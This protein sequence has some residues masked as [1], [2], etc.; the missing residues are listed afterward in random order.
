MLILLI[1]CTTPQPVQTPPEPV[2][3][4]VPKTVTIAVPAKCPRLIVDIQP[5]DPHAT[6]PAGSDITIACFGDAL[7]RPSM[8]RIQSLPLGFQD[9][10]NSP[11]RLVLEY[12]NEHEQTITAR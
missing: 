10:P 3:V 12:T 5:I 1:A 11:T 7:A 6:D 4:A 9:D 2:V 8:T